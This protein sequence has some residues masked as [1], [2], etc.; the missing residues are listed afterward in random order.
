VADIVNTAPLSAE[1]QADLT[2]LCGCIAGAAPAERIEGW[3]AGVGFVDVRVT[4][5]PESRELVK[6]W[7]PGRNL[8]DHV[9][10]AV[11]EARK[12]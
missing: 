3:L 9:V 1:L 12:P 6:S 2:L 4:P 8:E 5:K 11:V 10:S 7:A